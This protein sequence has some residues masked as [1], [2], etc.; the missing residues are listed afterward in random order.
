METKVNV[1]GTEISLRDLACAM[2]EAQFAGLIE[3]LTNCGHF[4]YGDG[5]RVGKEL[6]H[7]HRHL[8]MTAVRM[9][10]GILDGIGN[11]PA[12]NLDPRNETAVKVAQKVTQYQQGLW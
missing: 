8:Q 12:Y 9:V 6:Q 3:H 10:L 7:T 11:Q 2:S 5:V 1:N 4:G